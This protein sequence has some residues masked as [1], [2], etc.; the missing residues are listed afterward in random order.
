MRRPI[1]SRV[2]RALPLLLGATLTLAACGGVSGGTHDKGFPP[3]NPHVAAGQTGSAEVTVGA[4]RVRLP[5]PSGWSVVR[6]IRPRAGAQHGARAA[7]VTLVDRR[8]PCYLSAAVTGG[9][10]RAIDAHGIAVQYRRPSDGYGWR[11]EH[12][13]TG[14]LALL[15]QYDAAGTRLS[16]STLG[17]AY[18]PL[19]AHSYLAV[20]VG[21]GI[22]PLG[23]GDCSDTEV[24][25]RLGALRSGIATMIAGARVTPVPVAPA[26]E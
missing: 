1:V 23:D 18:L 6:P 13:G 12:V 11:L 19:A 4:F 7:L 3:A 2:T 26:A 15:D 5:V 14:M 21:A 8:P 16:R 17:T 10:R 20:D 25:R 24:S 22:W 9:T